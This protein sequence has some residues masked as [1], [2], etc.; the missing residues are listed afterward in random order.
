MF[1]PNYFGVFGTP[2]NPLIT[3]LGRVVNDS[4]IVKRTIISVQNLF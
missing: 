3:P 4:Y 2:G 1:V